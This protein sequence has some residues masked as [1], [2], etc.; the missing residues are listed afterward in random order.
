MI[1]IEDP[2]CATLAVTAGARST[3]QHDMPEPQ[4]ETFMG[5]GGS[6]FFVLGQHSCSAG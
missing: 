6:A 4:E 2:I 3:E 5:A 1:A